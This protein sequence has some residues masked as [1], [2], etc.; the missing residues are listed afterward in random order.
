MDR[1]LV[2]VAKVGSG[3]GDDED[4]GAGLGWEGRR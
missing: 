4:R 3:V 1:V 2:T